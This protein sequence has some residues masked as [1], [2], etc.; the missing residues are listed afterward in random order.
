MPIDAVARD[1]SAGRIFA[2]G[3]HVEL[4]ARSGL[5]LTLALHELTTNAVKYG[6]LFDDNGRVSVAW[7]IE[8]A[9]GEDTRALIWKKGGGPPVVPPSRTGFGSRMIEQALSSYVSGQVEM[10]YLP[11]GLVFRLTAPLANL[12]GE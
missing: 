11:D 8:G 2:E 6:A 12:T 1:Q 10:A 5:A 9:G 3:P 4:S 7:E